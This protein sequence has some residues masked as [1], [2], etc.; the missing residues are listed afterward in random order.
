MRDRDVRDAVRQK[1]AVDYA[2]DPQTRIVEEMGIWSG[3]VR[4][5]IA[6]I[7]GELWGYELKSERDTLKRLPEQ[8]RLYSRVFDRVTLVVGSRHVGAAEDAVPTWWGLTI[9]TGDVGCI[10][11]RSARK[12]RRNPSPDPYLVAQLLWR[13]EAVAVLEKFNLATGF[14]SKSVRL[15]HE[16][17]AAEL[18]LA[19]LGFE[20]RSM[21]KRRQ[22]WLG[23]AI[24]NEGQMAIN[25]DLD[26]GLPPP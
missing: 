4:I 9:A 21:L 3:T 14:R 7:N 19:D 6:V 2:G 12:G 13:D 8:A 22:L 24:S 5:D 26:P 10:R 1:L 20:V 11:L 17:L 16:R 25:P 15:I 23:Q 18:P